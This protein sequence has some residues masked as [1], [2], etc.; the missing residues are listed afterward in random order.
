MSS[1]QRI[2]FFGKLFLASLVTVL[3]ILQIFFVGR[4]NNSSEH[5]VSSADVKNA[6]EI[7][8]K[9]GLDLGNMQ[10]TKVFYLGNKVSSV[11]GRELY[12]G[13]PISGVDMTY[14][15]DEFGSLEWVNPGFQGYN[16][17]LRPRIPLLIGSLIARVANPISNFSGER[18]VY[19][20][21]VLY[22]TSPPSS[23]PAWTTD[24]RLAWE[25]TSEDG[26]LIAILDSLNG[27]PLYVPPSIIE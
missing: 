2:W 24:Y 6:G 17:T 27:F 18:R 21:L 22:A 11:H 5:L 10:I 14:F 16:G 19:G 9:N 7:F 15:F 1:K 26:K 23:D 4:I 12:K 13:V 25:F 8:K 3:L 20:E